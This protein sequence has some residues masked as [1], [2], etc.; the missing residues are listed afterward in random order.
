MVHEPG[1]ERD[2]LQDGSS[3]AKPIAA[4]PAKDVMGFAD[5]ST[6]PKG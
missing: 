4:A 1:P 2:L 5:S 6:Q 3:L